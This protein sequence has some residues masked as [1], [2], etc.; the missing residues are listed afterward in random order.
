MSLYALMTG[1]GTPTALITLLYDTNTGGGG[2][3]GGSSVRFQSWAFPLLSTGALAQ[4]SYQFPVGEDRPIQPVH[5]TAG[6][7]SG[8]L[9][10]PFRD[11]LGNPIPI[12]A[13]ATVTFRMKLEG[14][15]T[16]AID[17]DGSVEYG[18]LG[19]VSFAF[20]DTNPVPAAGR[21]NA[22]FQVAGLTM[23]LGRTIPITVQ[24]ALT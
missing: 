13:G 11:T 24:E 12:S 17:A 4:V 7:T 6:D 20:D 10:Y 5:L 15:D 21:Y 2:G 1:L 16:A 23:P 14:A 19:L 18:P 22:I 3:G 8:K 9:T